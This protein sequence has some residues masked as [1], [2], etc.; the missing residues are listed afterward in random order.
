MRLGKKSMPFLN[1]LNN[2]KFEFGKG[3]IVR[4][5]NKIPNIAKI[6]EIREYFQCYKQPRLGGK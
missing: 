2:L 1:E 5:G 4:E 6:G 3:R